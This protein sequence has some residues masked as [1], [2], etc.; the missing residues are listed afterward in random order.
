MTAHHA[1]A[2]ENRSLGSLAPKLIAG[3]LVVGLAGLGLSGVLTML[4]GGEHPLQDFFSSYLVSYAFFLSL[5][6][7][8]LFFVTLQHIT[9]S[10]W[11]VVI[12]RLAEGMTAWNFVLLAALFV[13]ILLVGMEELYSWMRPDVIATDHLVQHKQPYLNGKFFL[14]RWVVYFAAW[15]FYSFYFFGRSR[16][17]DHTGEEALTTQMESM[18]T[19]GMAAFALTATFASFDLLMSLE[20]HW[21]STIFGVYYFAGSALGI[22]SL[23]A[24]LSILLNRTGRLTRSIT[25]EHLHDLGR[26]MFGFVVFWAYI[27]FSQYML[28]WY[29]DIPEETGWYYYRQKGPWA[30]ASVALILLHFVLPFLILIG[31]FVKRRPFFLALMAVWLLAV[32]WFDMF[33]LVKPT[34]SHGAIPFGLM[35]IATFLGI[36]GLW[37]ACTAWQLSTAPLLCERDPRLPESLALDNA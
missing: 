10:G 4:S 24:L 2:A 3:G 9:R 32:H 7:G 14:I 16:E 21:F 28:I 6:L 23:L 5:S 18:S 29:A 30:I 11:S 15:I 8:A 1:Q 37:L 33:W 27:G 36:G 35:D 12:R 31:R 25:N 22:F 26:L 34:F 20:P 13:P 17:Q 19:H